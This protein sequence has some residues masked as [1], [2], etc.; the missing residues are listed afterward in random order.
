MGA[1][2]MDYIVADQIAIPEKR[3]E[4]YS[5][6]II[7]LPNSFLPAD[8]ERRIADRKF[9]RAEVGLPQDGFVFCCFNSSYKITPNVYEIWM[10]ILKQVDSNVLWLVATSP[11]AQRNL[12]SK[13]TAVGVDVK[14]LIFAPHM[15]LPEHQARL[16]LADLFLDTCPYNAGATASDTLWAGL[17]ILTRIGDTFVGRM[18]ASVLTAIGLPELIT[19]TPEAY[20]QMAIDLAT[21]PEKL[22]A[23]KR[24]LAEIRLTTP[25]FDTKLFTKHIEAAYIAM[26]ERHQAGLAPDHI[27]IPN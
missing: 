2:Y 13:A 18:A 8:R 20:E 21:Y 5:E 6:N 22:A 16:R 12:M 4:F 23:I 14:R 1:E 11:T 25:L 19:T 17:P 10:R 24:K 9:M 7:Y 15:S 26:H 3:R 27:S